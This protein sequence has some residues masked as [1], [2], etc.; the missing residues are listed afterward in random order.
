MLA[1]LETVATIWMTLVR[2]CLGDCLI[3]IDIFLQ[4]FFSVQVLENALRVLG[5]G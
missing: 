2:P 3:D 1:T 4:G 5:L